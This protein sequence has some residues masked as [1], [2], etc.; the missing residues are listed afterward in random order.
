MMAFG[1]FAVDYEERVDYPQ[2]RRGVRIEDMVLITENGCELL[3]R[4]PQELIVCRM[5]Y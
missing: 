3:S 1:K 2:L 4:F 5:P